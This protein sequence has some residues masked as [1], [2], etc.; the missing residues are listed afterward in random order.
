MLN[1]YITDR[2]AKRQATAKRD[3][4]LEQTVASTAHAHVHSQSKTLDRPL[5]QISRGK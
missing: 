5:E 4:A 3:E 1:R 2:Y